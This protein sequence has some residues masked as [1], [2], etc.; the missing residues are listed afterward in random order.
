MHVTSQYEFGVDART[1]PPGQANLMGSVPQHA[2]E[3]LRSGDG[4]L[5]DHRERES[6][7]NRA[8][9]GVQH[10]KRLLRPRRRKRLD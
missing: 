9:G 7:A 6:S 4:S 2:P 8:V 10:E 3:E 1:G 5:H